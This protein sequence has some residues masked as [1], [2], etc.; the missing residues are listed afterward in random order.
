[1]KT[2]RTFLIRLDMMK[3][4]RGSKASTERIGTSISRIDYLLTIGQSAMAWKAG[5]SFTRSLNGTAVKTLLI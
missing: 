5:Q 3:W 4:L 2:P 1:M